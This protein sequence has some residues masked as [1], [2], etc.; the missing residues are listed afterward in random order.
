M[1]EH[2]IVSNAWLEADRLALPE[3]VTLPGNSRP[4][5]ADV[6]ES[7]QTLG[8]AFTDSFTGP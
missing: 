2:M 1:F 6:Q 7:L 5:A 4:L 8:A 3:Q